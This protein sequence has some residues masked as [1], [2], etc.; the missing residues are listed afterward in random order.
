MGFHL[1]IFQSRACA[2]DAWEGL[3][4]GQSQ[5]FSLL[6]HLPEG[7]A[8]TSIQLSDLRLDLTTALESA[9]TN[10]AVRLLSDTDILL[11]QGPWQ[12]PVTL[13]LFWPVKRPEN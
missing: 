11:K 12:L 2:Q 5:Q 7:W 8:L 4:F 13:H 10:V 1:S 9:T 3:A 6:P